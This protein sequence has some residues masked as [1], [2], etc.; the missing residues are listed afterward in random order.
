MGSPV[1]ILKKTGHAGVQAPGVCHHCEIIRPTAD[2]AESPEESWQAAKELYGRFEEWEERELERL[3][4]VLAFADSVS[5][6]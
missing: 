3:R 4:T 1:G 2:A 6:K 5:C